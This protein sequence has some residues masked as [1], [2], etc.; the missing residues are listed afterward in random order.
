MTMQKRLKDDLKS[1]MR[2]GDN[3]R[4]GVIRYILS[5]IHNEEIAKQKALDEDSVIALMGKQAQQRRDSILAFS[6]GNRHDLADKEKNELA[7]IL[8]YLPQQMSAD[9][10]TDLVKIAVKEIEATGPQDMGKVMGNLMPKV[11]GKAQGKEVSTIV[12]AILNS[13][14]GEK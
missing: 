5:D 7:I 4:R 12:A 10:I 8:E 2:A 3:A 11:K 9:E 13:I 14:A 1:A 6:Q